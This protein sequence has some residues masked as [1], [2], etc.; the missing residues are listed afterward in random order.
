MSPVRLNPRRRID[1]W[2]WVMLVVIAVGLIAGGAAAMGAFSAAWIFTLW[3]I[4]GFAWWEAAGAI[5]EEKGIPRSQAMLLR[6][7]RD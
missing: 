6:I 3:P 4:L 2:L 5:A 1:R 7:P